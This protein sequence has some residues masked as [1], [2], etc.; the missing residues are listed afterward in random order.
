[1]LLLNNKCFRMIIFFIIKFFTLIFLCSRKNI[2]QL[3]IPL[4]FQ[5]N[6][7]TDTSL[8]NN[9]K[10]CQIFISDCFLIDLF[11]C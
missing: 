4:N 8:I 10:Q 6:P 5:K 7:Q 9:N 2:S 1:M 11:N 3:R